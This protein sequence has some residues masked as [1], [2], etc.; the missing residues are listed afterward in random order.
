MDIDVETWI[1]REGAEPPHHGLGRS[2]KIGKEQ[3]VGLVARCR[4]SSRATTTRERDRAPRLARIDR[5]RALDPGRSGSPAICTSTRASSSR[6]AGSAPAPRADRL[7]DAVPPIV[8][9]HAPLARGELV[10]APEA[11]TADDRPHVEAALADLA[12]HET[13]TRREPG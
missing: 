1:A 6:S 10:I 7:A 2:M 5:R 3:I 11:I 12:A 8:V 4:S 9:P 13:S